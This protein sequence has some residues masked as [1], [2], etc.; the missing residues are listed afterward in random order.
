MENELKI[1]KQGGGSLK[2]SLENKE[3]IWVCRLT[4]FLI[5]HTN[6]SFHGE[7]LFINGNLKFYFLGHISTFCVDHK[8]MSV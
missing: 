3:Y 2:S 6:H 7:L 1:C 8:R 4:T 5:K